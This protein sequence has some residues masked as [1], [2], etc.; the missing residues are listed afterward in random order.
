[1]NSTLST[2]S[3]QCRLDLGEL[4]IGAGDLYYL[5]GNNLAEGGC[6]GPTLEGA[7]AAAALA[8]ATYGHARQMYRVAAQVQ[9]LP[10]HDVGEDLPA[11]HSRISVGFLRRPLQ[12][13][14]GLMSGL[15]A[16]DIATSAVL[17]SLA[18]TPE[19]AV[20]LQKVLAE[21]EEN[22]WY[23]GGW[24]ESLGRSGGAVAGRLQSVLGPMVADM[25]TWVDQAGRLT[26]LAEAGLLPPPGELRARFER[27]LAE[28]TA[29]VDL[30]LAVRPE[31]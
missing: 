22:L 27:L 10:A 30:N 23:A 25:R 19:L 20:H 12:G 26:W 15:F 29:G 2:L 28:A 18:E 6:T 8:Q 9:D 24:I 16:V 11:A 3:P 5:V 21:T 7:V 1:M 4:F 14:V 31:V 13:W 17:Q